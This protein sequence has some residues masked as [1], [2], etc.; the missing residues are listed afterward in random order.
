[1]NKRYGIA[2]AALVLALVEASIILDRT[3]QVK[4]LP[5]PCKVA[6]GMDGHKYVPEGC[7]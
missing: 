2:L 1:M 5:H 6:Q 7:K 4:P 3:Q